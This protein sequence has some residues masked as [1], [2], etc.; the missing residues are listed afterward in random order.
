MLISRSADLCV[1]RH[2]SSCWVHLWMRRSAGSPRRFGS[3][4]SSRENRRALA[5]RPLA[6]GLQRYRQR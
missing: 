5:G 1:A 6:F 2:G 4:R 3:F